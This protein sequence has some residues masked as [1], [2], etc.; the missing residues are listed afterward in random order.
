MDRRSWLAAAAAMAAAGCGGALVAQESAVKTVQI[1]TRKFE[2]MPEE[3]TLAKGE[4]VI[5]ELIAD[6]IA[7]GFRC[8]ELNL[9]ADV[10]PGKPAQLRFTPHA[11]G[12]FHFYCDVFCGDGHEDMD[13]HITVTG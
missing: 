11:P 8:K 9:R 12:K 3:I 2:F 7:M 4:P 1:H 13:G 10:M 5:L 6:D